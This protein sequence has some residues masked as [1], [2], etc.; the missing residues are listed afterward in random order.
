LAALGG[1]VEAVAI[2][3]L[4]V[5]PERAVALVRERAIRGEQ[6]LEFDRVNIYRLHNGQIVEIWSYDFDPYALDAFWA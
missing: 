2:Q 3:D 1:T 5:G 4:L 6:V